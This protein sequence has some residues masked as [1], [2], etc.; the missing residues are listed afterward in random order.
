M[1]GRKP[2]KVPFIQVDAGRPIVLHSGGERDTYTRHLVPKAW[3]QKCDVEWR[4]S[5]SGREAMKHTRETGHSTFRL[6][7]QLDQF[8][9][10]GG[11]PF[12]ELEEAEE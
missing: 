3:C 1:S 10:R 12:P 4:G 7:G 5:K 11:S 2:K 6:S 8:V 9:V